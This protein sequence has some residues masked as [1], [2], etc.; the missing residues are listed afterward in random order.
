MILGKVNAFKQAVIP[1]S[2]HD[3]NGRAENVDAVIDT[4]FDGLLTVSSD[5]VSRL[6]LPFLETRSYELGDGNPV[7]LDIHRITVIWDGQDR[8]IE[9]LVTHSGVLVGMSMLTGY[10]LFIDAIDGGAVRIEPRT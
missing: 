3:S 7:N 2:L 6:Q 8:D 10:T 9:A 5:L 4:G 1:L